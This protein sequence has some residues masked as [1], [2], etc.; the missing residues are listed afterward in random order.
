MA[1]L[2]LA[3][4]PFELQEAFGRKCSLGGMTLRTR[5]MWSGVGPASSLNRPAVPVL[6][7]PDSDS[8]KE[9]A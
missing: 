6:G 4:L 3:S 5:N 1:S 9:P 2:V 7:F 8:G